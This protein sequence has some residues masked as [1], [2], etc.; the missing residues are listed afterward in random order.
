MNRTALTWEFHILSVTL[1]LCLPKK[2][3]GSTA[4]VPPPVCTPDPAKVV[5]TT[6]TREHPLW[7]SAEERPTANTRGVKRG[8]AEPGSP[9]LLGQPTLL[10]KERTPA[11]QLR[12]LPSRTT[13]GSPARDRTGHPGPEVLPRE[14]AP[15]SS[16]TGAPQLAP[17]GLAV[18][19]GELRVLIR[20]LST[21]THQ[22]T[23]APRTS[24]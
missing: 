13:P 6:G 21:V 10:R 15:I 7:R 14:D 1:F 11:P 17:A 24:L 23:R 20:V 2:H 4:E 16:E 8:H 3:P 9:C 19:A 12:V 5:T 18:P 22:E